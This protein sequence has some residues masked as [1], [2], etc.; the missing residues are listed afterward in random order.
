MQALRRRLRGL[1]RR[2]FRHRS[3]T[4]RRPKGITWGITEGITSDLTKKV[5]PAG[6]RKPLQCKGLRSGDDAT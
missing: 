2:P 1:A 3:A 6:N 4:I 5:S